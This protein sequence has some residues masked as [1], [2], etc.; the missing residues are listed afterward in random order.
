MLF[1]HRIPVRR[2]FPLY[3]T[4]KSTGLQALLAGL[5]TFPEID[6]PGE[7][8]VKGPAKNAPSILGTVHKS[9]G[10]ISLIITYKELLTNGAFCIIMV[11]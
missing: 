8:H 11:Q 10:F 3:Y 5:V 7:N 9:S 2:L 1:C 4:T 6:H